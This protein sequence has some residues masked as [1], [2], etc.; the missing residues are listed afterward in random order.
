[1][2]PV[3]PG[4]A[5]EA[6][7]LRKLRAPALIALAAAVLMVPLV[8]MQF[9]DEVDWK[10]F[11]FVLAGAV[12]FSGGMAFRVISR[13][14]TILVYRGGVA[15]GLGSAML[16]AW[17][18]G[19]VGIIGSEEN[20]AN[21]LYLFVLLTGLVGA[22]ICRFHPRGMART[23]LAA[24]AVQAV[25][26]VVAIIAVNVDALSWGEFGEM[27]GASPTAQLLFV[28]GLFI[29]LFLGSARLFQIAA[30]SQS[31]ADLGL[32]APQSRR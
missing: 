18:N 21:G 14:M 11:D 29:A 27:N 13:R 15:V 24:A 30:R 4:N 26:T 20:D 23:L 5:R 22:L 2:F 7:A 10:L 28:N 3:K 9:S 16:L 12:L 6:S 17:V 31:S 32:E 1:M 19:A 8:A 25:I